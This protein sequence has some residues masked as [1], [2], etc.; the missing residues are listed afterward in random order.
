MQEQPL[1]EIPVRKYFNPSDEA[2]VVEIH[3]LPGYA[4]TKWKCEPRGVVEGPSNYAAA[5]ARQGL[6]PYAGQKIGVQRAVVSD[7]PSEEA[8][9]AES[10]EPG[11]TIPG[12]PDKAKRGG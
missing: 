8:K 9:D 10:A 7:E 2:R 4:P 12:K 11:V 1:Q 5:F 6:V 3:Q